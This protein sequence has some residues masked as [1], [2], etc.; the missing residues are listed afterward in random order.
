MRA[1]THGLNPTAEQANC[2]SRNEVPPVEGIDTSNII[3]P[4]LLLPAGVE[5]RSRPLR[6]LTHFA[7]PLSQIIANVEMRS[8]PLR[9]LTHAHRQTSFLCIC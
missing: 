6:A 5:M 2:E 8:R 7:P 1:L 9:A 4:P 3:S